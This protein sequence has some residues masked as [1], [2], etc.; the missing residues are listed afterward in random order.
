M[1][2]GPKGEK[3]PADV[4]GAAVMVAK[5][6][7]WCQTSASAVTMAD[8]YCRSVSGEICGSRLQHKP[9][10]PTWKGALVRQW[11]G[12]RLWSRPHAEFA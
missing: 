8:L 2:K 6:A 5:I 11:N 7:T 9:G 4:I 10:V 12:R 1:P 3:R